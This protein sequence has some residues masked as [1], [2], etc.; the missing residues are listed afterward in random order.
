MDIDIQMVKNVTTTDA[1]ISTT[2]TTK[3]DKMNKV[4]K[5]AL[6]NSCF[7][8]CEWQHLIQNL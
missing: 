7:K 3:S 2:K 1:Q 8:I 5:R 6:D 4:Q